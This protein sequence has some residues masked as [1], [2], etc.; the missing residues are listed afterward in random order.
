M[1]NSSVAFTYVSVV[2]VISLGLVLLNVLT[3]VMLY[4]LDQCVVFF[5]IKH[6]RNNNANEMIKMIT[7]ENNF[8]EYCK[9]INENVLFSLF[10]F[11]SWIGVCRRY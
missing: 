4:R 3:F 11:D 6:S 7:V 10:I 1:S 5:W 2:H 9:L 8:D